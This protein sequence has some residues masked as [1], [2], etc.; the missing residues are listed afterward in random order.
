MGFGAAG[1]YF[2]LDGQEFL[3]MPL[4][5]NI[6]KSNISIKE[7]INANQLHTARPSAQWFL[8]ML[9]KG[10]MSAQGDGTL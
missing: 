3:A 8:L 10:A 9:I 4:F 5:G 2:F 6:E 1:Q 7:Q